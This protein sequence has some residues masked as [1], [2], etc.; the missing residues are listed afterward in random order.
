MDIKELHGAKIKD[1]MQRDPR[2]ITRLITVRMLR[3]VHHTTSCQASTSCQTS[4][5]SYCFCW[6][7]H[8]I[9]P[10][11]SQPGPVHA[12]RYDSI[13][14]KQMINQASP[15]SST[16]CQL[17]YHTA[18]SL[19]LTLPFLLLQ[20]L[21]K[22]MH[23]MMHEK[24]KR[25]AQVQEDQACVD[26]IN[27]TISNHVQPQL[28]S[29]APPRQQHSLPGVSGIAATVSMRAWCLSTAKRL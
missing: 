9:A 6:Y 3:L 27:D 20:Q 2:F 23:S 19:T 4:H 12:A 21:D 26:K 16:T 8:H 17:R 5:G 7:Q 25:R 14:I 13:T 11:R 15:C 28:V 10:S 1:L 22:Q 18:N 24:E 29:C